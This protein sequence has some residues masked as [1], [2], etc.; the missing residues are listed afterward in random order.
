MKKILSLNGKWDGSY[1]LPGEQSVTFQGNVPGCAHTDLLQE[2]KIADPFLNSQAEECQFIEKAVFEY[3]KTFVFEESTENVRLH[4]SCLDTYCDI[5]LN[6]K[7]LGFCN[8]MFLPWEFD[9]SKELQSGSNELKVRFYPPAE[10]VKD[11]PEYIACFTTERV[12][13]R[14]MQC[15]FGWDWV[16]RFVTMGIMGDVQLCK[17][18]ETEIDN[19]YIATTALDNYGAELTLQ[20]EFKEVGE[21]TSLVWSIL[22]PQGDVVWQQRRLIVENQIRQR[23]SLAEPELWWPNGYGEQPLYTLHITVGDKN[24]QV[25]QDIDIT[26][27]IRTIRILELQDKEGSENWNISK[28]MQKLSHISQTDFNEEYFGFQVLVNGYPIFCKGANWVPCEPFPSAV[29]D[30]KCKELL[31]L[32]AEAHL[33]MLRVWGGGLIESETFY[34]TCDKLGLLVIQDFQMA[35]GEYPEDQQDFLETLRK[36]GAY[37]A[38]RIRNHPSLAWWTGDNENSSEGHLEKKEYW[39]RRAANLA[40]EPMVNK[41][42]PYRRFLPSS[43]YGGKPFES[44]TSGIAHSTRHLA[45]QFG[46]FKESDLSD[47]HEIMGA[48]LSRFNS[49]IPVFGAPSLSSM[50]RF[51]S[52]EV[53]YDD[54]SL[55]FHTKNNPIGLFKEFTIYDTHKTFS[56]KLL[57]TFQN[58]ENRLLKMRCIQYEWV[59]YTME[60]YRRNRRYAGGALFWMYNDCW[61]ANSWSVVDYYV[62]PKAGWYALKNSCRK[63]IGSIHKEDKEFIVTIMNDGK[64]DVAGT[65]KIT[66]WNVHK[67]SPE[68]QQKLPFIASGN[69]VVHVLNIE[70]ELPEKHHLL[71]LEVETAGEEHPYR[72]VYFPK[73]IADIGLP[74]EDGETTVRVVEKTDD[75]ITLY[76]EKYTHM[77]D[78]DGDY[79]FEDNF[80]T[81]LPGET[82]TIGFRPTAMAETSEIN[83]FGL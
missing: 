65:A 82:K 73:R 14:R 18:V 79:I 8:N 72:T 58:E 63:V 6:G 13:I 28:K 36:E 46:R 43:P 9:V 37:A 11:C 22:S 83:V 19:V 69:E 54:K 56:E 42:D 21:D 7:H 35:C 80:F 76:A 10:Q 70:W 40:L 64:K 62:N 2:G 50:K 33:T 53:L 31:Q 45:W 68:M 12:H 61:P 39:G 55:E 81:M 29:T 51:L 27:G 57:G 24:D 59:R 48:G 67:K 49:E 71:L 16:E 3:T 74:S 47:Y 34:S 5:W 20:T 30:E 23:V 60:L 15:T 78:L 75:S 52:K 77:V 41:Y 25:I 1:Q 4:F 26:F 38:K 17:Y 32:A 66:L 44:V